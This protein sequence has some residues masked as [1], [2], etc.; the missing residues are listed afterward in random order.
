MFKR[1]LPG[2]D[3]EQIVVSPVEARGARIDGRVIMVLVIGMA[4]AI[5]A[6]TFFGVQG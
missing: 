2:H 4:M 5:G 1:K 3:E 6:M